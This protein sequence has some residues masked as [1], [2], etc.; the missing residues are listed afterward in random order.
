MKLAFKLNRTTSH[1]KAKLIEHKLEY[2]FMRRKQ[3]SFNRIKSYTRYLDGR[4]VLAKKMLGTIHQ[5]FTRKYNMYNI[6]YMMKNTTK[7]QTGRYNHVKL[8]VF[9]LERVLSKT[10][11]TVLKT[12]FAQ[13]SSSYLKD[14]LKS[15]KLKLELAQNQAD[16]FIKVPRFKTG[17]DGSPKLLAFTSHH[18]L[19]VVSAPTTNR[20]YEQK[21]KFNTNNNLESET[22]EVSSPHLLKRSRKQHMTAAMQQF[23]FSPVAA[24]KEQGRTQSASEENNGTAEPHEPKQPASPEQNPQSHRKVNTS[25]VESVALQLPQD[26]DGELPLELVAKINPKTFKSSESKNVS[27]AEASAA[28]RDLSSNPPKLNSFETESESNLRAG[29][30]KF[31]SSL[32]VMHSQNLNSLRVDYIQIKPA[33]VKN[34]RDGVGRGS[35]M[36][37]TS[38]AKSPSNNTAP[39]IF[40]K[41]VKSKPGLVSSGTTKASSRPLSKQGSGLKEPPT[42]NNIRTKPE[43]RDGSLRKPAAPATNS[44]LATSAA[45]PQLAASQ[46]PGDK[47]KKKLMFAK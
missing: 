46:S 6:F 26:D 3:T 41:P 37:T 17:A 24:D 7:Y 40:A 19:P 30:D 29:G 45:K 42:G 43:S 39:G 20:P 27:S 11:R 15:R 12:Y 2:I 16:H 47:P 21:I 13:V 38:A 4:L 18:E 28:R 23:R 5:L 33:A 9:N 8:A 14:T 32:E 10:V 44:R 34:G 36:T 31:K 35:G 25:S 22:L 1:S